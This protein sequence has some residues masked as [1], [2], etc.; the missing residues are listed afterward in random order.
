MLLAAAAWIDP[1]LGRGER[2]VYMDV[3]TSHGPSYGDTLT[4]SEQTKPALPLNKVHAQMEVDLPRLQR[5]LV[6]LL[7]QPAPQPSTEDLAK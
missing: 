5:F 6:D 1:T 3:D 7:S 2:Y 4:W